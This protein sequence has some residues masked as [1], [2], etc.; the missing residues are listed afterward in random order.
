MT[1]GEWEDVLAERILHP[2]D[3]YGEVVDH[4]FINCDSMSARED[5]PLG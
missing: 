3:T 4:D 2:I 1:L 5:S